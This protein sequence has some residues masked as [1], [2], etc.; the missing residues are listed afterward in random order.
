MYSVV[1]RAH[2]IRAEPHIPAQWLQHNLWAKYGP[3]LNFFC[4]P[5]NGPDFNRILPIFDGW[6]A[7][8][9]SHRVSHMQL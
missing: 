6:P 2:S 3:E 7:S 9:L 8:C 1:L 5:Q 4:G